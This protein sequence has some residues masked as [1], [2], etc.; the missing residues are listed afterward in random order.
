MQQI[1]NRI[2][3]NGAILHVNNYGYLE[4][5]GDSKTKQIQATNEITGGIMVINCDSLPFPTGKLSR[6][7]RLLTIK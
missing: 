2:A 1:P 3:F 4:L 6:F 5:I 7:Q